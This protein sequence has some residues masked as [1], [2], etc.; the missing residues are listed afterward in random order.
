MPIAADLEI[1]PDVLLRA[2]GELITVARVV[3]SVEWD[4]AGSVAFAGTATGDDGTADRWGAAWGAWS[5]ALLDLSDAM[6]AVGDSLHVALAGYEAA[7]VLI[8]RR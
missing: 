8:T 7:D 1:H 6:G 4:L 5:Q 2:S 3:R